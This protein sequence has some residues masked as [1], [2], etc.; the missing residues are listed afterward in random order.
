MQKELSAQEKRILEIVT[1]NPSITLLK[2]EELYVNRFGKE[3]TRL[4]ICTFLI[5]MEK[6]GY[7]QKIQRKGQYE[8]SIKEKH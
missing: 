1:K 4:S 6:L 2:V 3:L 5:R 7:L 8:F